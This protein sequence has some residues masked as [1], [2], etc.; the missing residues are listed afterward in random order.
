MLNCGSLATILQNHRGRKCPITIRLRYSK[1]GGEK[2]CLRQTVKVGCG[3]EEGKAIKTESDAKGF[4]Q[5]T[6]WSTCKK[7][8]AGSGEGD[9][10]FTKKRDSGTVGVRKRIK[11]LETLRKRDLRGVRNR[12]WKRKK[13]P[14]GV[15]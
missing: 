2:K 4:R 11:Q 7:K 8:G 13:G 9:F 10:P 3:E 5:K 15:K 14:Q 1:V 6:R 12:W